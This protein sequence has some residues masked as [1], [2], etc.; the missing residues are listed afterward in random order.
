MSELIV[1]A[2]M[3]GGSGTRLWPLSRADKPK[4]FLA[5]NDDSSLFQNSVARVKSAEFSPP[6]FLTNKN[7]LSLIEAQLPDTEVTPAGVILEP[8][9]RG[10]AAAIAAMIVAISRKNAEA[11]ILVMPADHVITEAQ[12][13]REAIVRATPVAK[14][15]KIVTFGIVPTSPETGYGY[16]RRENEIVLNDAIVGYTVAQPGGFLEKPDEAKAKKFV[17]DG[18]LWNAGIFLFKASTMLQEF[19]KYAPEALQAATAAVVNGT[20]TFQGG[21]NHH[22]LCE[23]AF[24]QAPSGVSVDTAIMEQSHSVAVI[25]CEDIG[26]CDVG[27]LSALWDMAKKDHANN[28]VVGNGII[29]QS[30]DILIYSETGRK[31]VASNLDGVMIVDT[32]DALMVI[33]RHKAQAVK[34]VFEI[35]KSVNAP[36]LSNSSIYHAYWGDVMVKSREKNFLVA[37]VKLKSFRSFKRSQ[38]VSVAETWVALDDSAECTLDGTKTVLAHGQSIQIQENQTIEFRASDKSVSFIVICTTND[39]LVSLRELFAETKILQVGTLQ[40]A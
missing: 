23:A 31:I 14:A 10:T 3:I 27:S 28:A 26:W 25:P 32:D 24:A 17:E 4:Q 12:R 8:L 29:H 38:I 30:Q 7:F 2:I 11:L 40:V 13:F 15:G 37:T 6:W 39:S 35:L 5:L 21:V 20:S 22:E 9:Q 34:D 1:P 16:I 36:E 18:Y 19:K 33:P